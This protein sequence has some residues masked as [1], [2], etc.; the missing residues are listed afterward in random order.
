MDGKREG[1]FFE[2]RWSDQNFLEIDLGEVR[3][4]DGVRIFFWHGDL[5]YYQFYVLS[6]VDGKK[7]EMLYDERKNLVRSREEGFGKDFPAKKMRF[8]RVF[9]LYNSV[10]AACH[11][12]EVEIYGTK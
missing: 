3:N 7:W 1:A 8:V 4:A 9:V 2:S 12:R 5:R 10:N 11:I 6:S